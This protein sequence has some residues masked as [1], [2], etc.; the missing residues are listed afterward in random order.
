MNRPRWTASASAVPS[1]RTKPAA[2][3]SALAIPH[4]TSLVAQTVAA[5]AS[6]IE[7]GAWREW[8][9][10]ERTLC[11]T[12]QIS[13]TTLRVALKQLEARGLVASQ[14]GAGTR[15]LAAAP[16]APVAAHP[17]DVALLVPEPLEALRPSQTLWIDELRALLSERG[18]RLRVF[19]GSQY[20]RA[21][22]SEALERLVRE[23]PHGAWILALANEPVQ[24]WF[25]RS[26]IPC[27]VAGSVYPGIEL[28][29]RDYD[30]RAI[31][32][33]AA[34]TLVRLG[35]RRL[36]FFSLAAPR[37]GDLE[38]EAGFMEGVKLSQRSDVS[39]QVVGL[40]GGVERTCGFVRRLMAQRDR[41][42][43]ILVA[44]ASH[45]LTVVTQLAQLG[46]GVPHDVSVM[47]RD[48]DAF[49]GCLVPRPSCFD[50]NAHRLARA[51]LPA[52]TQ[53][54]DGIPVKPRQ[55]LL[56]PEFLA[57]RSHAA[58]PAEHMAF[59]AAG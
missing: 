55:L 33:H 16:A 29:F 39:V 17:A 4:R 32:R 37:A 56:V 50:A 57:G 35:H 43:G 44:R 14:H 18:T 38:S 20:F 24:A 9:P 41:P 27:V 34:G 21:D 13:R 5:L 26:R 12:L 30:H 52:V 1:R 6:H 42:T 45:Y 22:P 54:L 10:P 11:A 48:D 25:M 8:L 23:H 2:A 51:L 28:P 15:I 40:D 46:L 49:L 59:A 31:C 47:A 58:A 36:V 3:P 53:L 7:R 19:S